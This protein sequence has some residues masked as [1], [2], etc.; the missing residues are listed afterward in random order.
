MPLW[1]LM[2]LS[3]AVYFLVRFRLQ[4]LATERL[5][6]DITTASIARAATVG[7][8]KSLR[9]LAA[10]ASSIAF[11]VYV[12][13][14][15]VQFAGFAIRPLAEGLLRVVNGAHSWSSSVDQRFAV[16]LFVLSLAA[17]VWLTRRSAAKDQEQRLGQA[18]N[19]ELERLQKQ[20]QQGGWTALPPTPAMVNLQVKA[21]QIQEA[22]RTGAYNGQ[23]L[24]DEGRKSCED[25]LQELG[26]R[27]QMLDVDRRI[28][29]KVELA[30][31]DAGALAF[32]FSAKTYGALR[33][34]KKHLGQLSAATAMAGLVGVVSPA[35]AAASATTQI[36]LSD[37]IVTRDAADAEQ[38]WKEHKTQQ[39]FAPDD[40]RILNRAAASFER[41]FARSLTSRVYE[42]AED[43]AEVR[44]L[45]AR[46]QVIETI[47]EKSHSQSVAEYRSMADLPQLD[48]QADAAIRDLSPLPSIEQ[49]RT[50]VG[51]RFREQLRQR[52]AGTTA[53][54]RLKV[55]YGG[56]FDEPVSLDDLGAELLDEAF[57]GV[58]RMGPKPT[59]G[60]GEQ[61]TKVLED[62]PKTVLTKYY[63]VKSAQFELEIA[64]G[65][66][67]AAISDA[68]SGRQGLFRF[69]DDATLTKIN[70]PRV[71][72]HTALPMNTL[73][74]NPPRLRE[75]GVE[76]KA[77]VS[78][79]YNAIVSEA[80]TLTVYEDY[81]PGWH[82]AATTTARN[83][84]L[85]RAR[86]TLGIDS[87]LASRIARLSA[88]TAGRESELLHIAIDPKAL[89]GFSR[90]G[91]VVIGEMPTHVSPAGITRLQ[92]AMNGSQVSLSVVANGQPYSIGT[93]PTSIVH[94][95][96][97]YSADNRRLAVTMLIGQ[98]PDPKGPPHRVI[99]HPALLDTS[100]GAAL[101]DVDQLVF[102]ATAGSKLRK[103]LQESISIQE[104]LYRLAVL[105][106][107]SG[108]V[109]DRV[110]LSPEQV[111][112]KA[113]VDSSIATQQ[114]G[115]A[116]IHDDTTAI[117][118]L[119]AADTWSDGSIFRG[120][121]EY[122]D[123]ET[124]THM[125]SVVQG[126]VRTLSDFVARMK[127]AK[128]SKDS[129]VEWLL[130]RIEAFGVQINS[131]V[132]EKSYAIDATR[133]FLDGQGPLWPLAFKI[134]AT[135]TV[136]PQKV[137]KSSSDDDAVG[138]HAWVFP[139]SGDLQTTAAVVRWVAADTARV[140]TVKTV[141]DFTKLQRLF[142]A[143]FDGALGDG[144]ELQSVVGLAQSLPAEQ[145]TK[146]PRWAR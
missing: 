114:A 107:L 120:R 85:S 16:A 4:P 72:L 134:L 125:H 117:E 70:S 127:N 123:A 51:L 8:L 49:P 83:S 57:G 133:S 80:D 131:G 96:L 47:T 82:G 130:K 100:V 11:G 27:W 144:F 69:L 91:G 35:V 61:L 93:Y 48:K 45:W 71:D 75:V 106:R 22:L 128:L 110:V 2:A 98:N 66:D 145:P 122:Y 32:L 6:S 140:A 103:K 129:N 141:Q 17:M 65:S 104:A 105:A 84:F 55:T 53:W 112:F 41:E 38:T 115:L 24:N 13:T 14:F 121:P 132:R 89:D 7:G 58:L 64:R 25:A 15:S 92:W 101:I 118:V 39:Q 60:L 46:R 67:A 88:Q 31:H 97:G 28:D 102:D 23:R 9:S 119:T 90:V 40:E 78:P 43:A 18:V 37:L 44:R 19:R 34:F 77:N 126:G 136:P 142:R 63:E 79:T 87:D 146:T 3:L 20:A 135:F 138:T 143:A 1:T 86:S 68:V 29:P 10:I 74:E 109:S 99:L 56:S 95:A 50:S 94:A 36:R 59:S 108:V 81:F 5:R 116:S 21:G 137:G 30:N 139:E 26:R 52:V 124:V 54:E 62:I 113:A 33:A 12:L 73:R 111:K 42:H 76:A